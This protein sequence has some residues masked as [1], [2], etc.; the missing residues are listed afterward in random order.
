MEYFPKDQEKEIMDYGEIAR[1][2]I[3]KN[4]WK[5][6][7]QIEDIAAFIN[8]DRSYLFRKFKECTGRSMKQYL[9]EYRM[10]RACELLR[11]TN[12]SV[13]SVSH[14]VGYQD[15]LYFSKVFSKSMSISPSGYIKQYREGL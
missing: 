12:L 4:Y 7:L 9:S 15:P 8:I 5:P 13:K 14:S 11:H 3:E 6:D 2:Y 10:E 1:G